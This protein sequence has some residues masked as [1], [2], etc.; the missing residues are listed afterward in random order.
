MFSITL[1]QKVCLNLFRN[2]LFLPS[3]ALVNA[4]GKSGNAYI[5]LTLKKVH[6]FNQY[7][8]FISPTVTK[9]DCYMGEG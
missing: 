6:L 9:E 7:L 3:Q 4:G 5:Q 8:N 2:Q 1:S